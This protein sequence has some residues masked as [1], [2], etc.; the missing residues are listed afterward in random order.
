MRQDIRDKVGI[1]RNITNT[2]KRLFRIKK[3]LPELFI[4]TLL[5]ELVRCQSFA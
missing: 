4:N 5:E 2:Y 3:F 1:S